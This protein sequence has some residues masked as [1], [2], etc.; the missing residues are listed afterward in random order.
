MDRNFLYDGKQ[1]VQV[2]EQFSELSD[3]SSGIPQGSVFGPVLFVIYINDLP[4]SVISYI[5]LYADETKMYREIQSVWSPYLKKHIHMIENVQ[6]RA[7]KVIPGFNKLSY[8]KRLKKLK[9][10]TLKYRRL[11]GDMIEVYKC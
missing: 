1:R 10:P 4:D 5:D 11:K 2:N 6:R 8:E 7:K 3:V 9:L